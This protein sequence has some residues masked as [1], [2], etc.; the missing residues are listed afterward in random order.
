[1]RSHEEFR[2]LLGVF[3][4][5]A[6]DDAD[7]RSAVEAHLARCPECRREVDEHRFV[8]GELAETELGAPEGLWNRIESE[9]DDQVETPER[10]GWWPIHG[11]TSIAATVAVVAAIGMTALW[12]DADSEVEGL[13]E[14]IS[15]LEAG[16]EQAELTLS[17]DPFDLAVERA[18]SQSDVFEVTI[19]GEIGSS[20]AVVLPDGRGWLTDVDFASLESTRT[21]Q[22]WAIQDGTVI[23][24]GVFGSTPGTVA[25]HVDADLLDGLVITIE[26][27]GGV[28]SSSNPAAAA[29]LADA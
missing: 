2:S 21:Y 18:R 16:L 6:I 15:E 19:G 1:M 26:A 3:A 22:L 28:V 17:Q 4:L 11:L 7:E 9:L 23:S 5:D 29:W 20:Q 10:S 27:A 13:R 14:R 12:A 8:A 24:A 25:F